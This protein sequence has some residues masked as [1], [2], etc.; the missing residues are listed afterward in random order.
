[1][2]KIFSQLATLKELGTFSNF[3]NSK[4]IKKTLELS[5]IHSSFLEFSLASLIQAQKI[6]P[7][8]ILLVFEN[9]LEAERH[10]S[11][12]INISPNEKAFLFTHSIEQLHEEL[13]QKP[14]SANARLST[15]LEM[16]NPLKP[17]L[18]FTYPEALLEKIPTITS[19]Q[20]NDSA[21]LFNE[22]LTYNT[23][24]QFL[25]KH[26]FNKV[27]FVENPGEYSLRG[28][29]IDF[30]N[31]GSD[32]AYRI[33]YGVEKIEKIRTFNLLDQLSERTIS[34]LKINFIDKEL[35]ETNTS[36]NVN[37]LDIHNENCTYILFNEEVLIEKI[38]QF[39]NQL[40]SEFKDT[41]KTSEVAHS[42]ELNTAKSKNFF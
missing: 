41:Q 34:S 17:Q 5:G 27:G 16:Q 1:M 39:Q 25:K 24:L 2:N 42:F 13:I 20:N 30:M 40:I 37:F 11:S 32:I 28:S 15:I 8:S 3:L 19:S 23:L 31:Y 35:I 26:N 33:E 36:Q 29:I 18:V 14:H 4:N 22:N 7:Q 9:S 12:F 38:V 10:W 21:L 6:S